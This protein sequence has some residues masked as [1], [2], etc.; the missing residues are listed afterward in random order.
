MC[1]A[2]R[3]GPRSGLPSSWKAAPS[4]HRDALPAARSRRR[5]TNRGRGG[6]LRVSERLRRSSHR[7]SGRP[8]P[9]GRETAPSTSYCARYRSTQGASRPHDLLLGQVWRARAKNGHETRAGHDQE[10]PRRAGRRRRTAGLNRQRAQRGLPHAPSG[11][12]VGVTPPRRVACTADRASSASAVAVRW[13]AAQNEWQKG[14][15]SS[16]A[17][18]R[19]PHS[20]WS[21]ARGCQRDGESESFES[22][23]TARPSFAVVG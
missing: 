1:L 15:R 8:M 6:R 21:T 12:D 17:D 4:S 3:V 19:T 10:P 5:L 22:R 20:R 16:P 13:N 2:P 14:D 18:E 11:R 7:K 9:S 23:S